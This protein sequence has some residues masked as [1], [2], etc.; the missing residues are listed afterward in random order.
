MSTVQDESSEKSPDHNADQDT[1]KERRAGLKI[2]QR[3]T[4]RIKLPFG[5]VRRLKV[6]FN[7]VG[8][9]RQGKKQPSA[10]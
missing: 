7:H 6:Q 8:K 3:K 5:S 1:S 10:A 2:K 9:Q 4:H